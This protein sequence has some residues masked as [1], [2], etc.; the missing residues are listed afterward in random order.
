MYIIKF[1]MKPKEPLTPLDLTKV[2][3]LIVHHAEASIFS[4]AQVNDCHKNERNWNCAG[5]N[6]YVRKDGTV[7]EMRGFNQGAQTLGYN[8]IS[9]G[10]CLEGN[11]ERESISSTQYSA[12]ISLLNTLKVKFPNAK[13]V[14]HRDLNKTACPGKNIDLDK[15]NRSVAVTYP[16]LKIGHKGVH[17]KLLQQALKEAGYNLTVDGD[18]GPL[19]D[20]AVRDY[21]AKNKL[22][23]D[24]IAGPA[25]WRCLL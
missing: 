18:F 8:E 24:G 14:G 12:L 16:I 1:D 10:I 20:G 21:Q 22:S 25:T 15:I 9:L 6:F 4:P 17:V 19:T 23:V 11:F 3:Y 13:I 7:Y 2:I 5:Y